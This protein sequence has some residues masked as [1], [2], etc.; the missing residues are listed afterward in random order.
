ALWLAILAAAADLP[1]D[2]EIHRLIGPQTTFALTGGVA[3]PKFG[4]D[5]LSTGVR[6]SKQHSHISMSADQ[7]DF[8]DRQSLLKEPADCL[9]PQVME[10]QIIYSGPSFQSLPSQTKCV[11]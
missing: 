2:R 6:I 8:R 5:L 10:A 3:A 7:R 9:M 11:R 4:N 1:G